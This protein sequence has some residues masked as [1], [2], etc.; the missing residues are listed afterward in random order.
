MTLAVPKLT[1]R[2]I[3]TQAERLI[4]SYLKRIGRTRENVAAIG[5][6]D[7][8]VEFIYPEY[9]VNLLVDQDLGVTESGRAILGS[10]EVFENTVLISKLLSLGSGDQRRAFTLCHEFGHAITHGEWLRQASHQSLSGRR[11]VTTNESLSPKSL[12]TLEWQANVFAANVAAPRW[13]VEREILRTF[14]PKILFRFIKPGIQG[15]EVRGVYVT[16]QVDSYLELCRTIAEFIRHRFGGLSLESLSYR[17][18]DSG[19]VLDLSQ[20]KLAL[21][22]VA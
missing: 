2:E 11:L 7:V 22:R 14:A 15:F 19:Y 3:V 6:D 12:K 1:E 9:G 17:V 20:R 16:R 10:Y 21:K 18:R 13:L 5:I 8:Y 4:D